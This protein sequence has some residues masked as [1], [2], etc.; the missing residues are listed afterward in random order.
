MPIEMWERLRRAVEDAQDIAD[1]KRFD[2]EDDGVRFPAPVALAIADGAQ[3][4][5]AWREHR[6]LTLQALADAASVSKPYVSQIEGVKRAG[7]TATLKKL[8]RA[9]DV[10]LGA[11]TA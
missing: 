2:R 10:P 9:L 4:V 5:R 11:L 3:P 8:A 7:T 6:W 1:L